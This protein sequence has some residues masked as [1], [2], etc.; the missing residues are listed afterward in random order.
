[1]STIRSLRQLT[2]VSRAAAG[3]A[4]S[5]PAVTR[6]RL[7]TLAARVTLPATRAFSVSAR[8]FTEGSCR[9]QTYH[10]EVAN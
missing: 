3:A 5:T 1:M 4:R 6:L 7:A 8:S 9:S 2:A 10:S